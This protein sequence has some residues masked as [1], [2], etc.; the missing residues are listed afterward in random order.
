MGS[1]GA[2]CGAVR[3]PCRAPCAVG[4]EEGRPRAPQG[5]GPFVLAF[6]A[7]EVTCE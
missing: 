4:D 3:G 6:T 5:H 2:S 1:G 7:K